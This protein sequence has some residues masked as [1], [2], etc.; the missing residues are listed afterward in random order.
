MT[1]CPS[2]PYGGLVS[3][4]VDTVDCH[5][6]VL[7]HESYRE[8][9]GPGTMFA[10]ALTALLTIYIALLGYQILIGRGGLRV[11]D[12]PV[13]ALKIGL[14]LAFVTSWAAYQT[15]F[16]NLLF[17]GPREI[18][19]VLLRPMARMGTGFNGDVYGGLE[20]AYATLSGA[21]GVYGGQASPAA[22]ILQGGPMLGSGILWLSAIVMLLAT[23]GVILAAKIILAFLL[24][25]GP[26]FIGL[27]LFAPTRGLFDGWLRSTIAFALA[28]LA[29][30]VFGAAMLM[31]MQPFLLQLNAYAMDRYFDMGTIIT[32]GLIVAVFTIVMLFAMRM[33]AGIAAGF[34]SGGERASRTFGGQTAGN[35]PQSAQHRA[36]QMAARLTVADHASAPAFPAARRAR[37]SASAVAE[38]TPVSQRL[39][40]AYRRQ[41]QPRASG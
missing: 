2:S 7:V 3:G 32:I 21:A 39:G 13:A 12:L 10:T 37:E 17:D 35:A 24:A 30:N 11:T 41:P 19:Q 20:S 40:Q 28:P 8:L 6:R 25:V 38:V 16:F 14:I 23:V 36:E 1:F 34:A 29:V 15:V 31:M 22:N 18:M 27:F 5:I 26:I 4:L 33:G 9:V